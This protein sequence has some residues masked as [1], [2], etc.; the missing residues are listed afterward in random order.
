MWRRN[1]LKGQW[2]SRVAMPRGRAALSGLWMVVIEDD[3]NSI[4]P[5]VVV[6]GLERHREYPDAF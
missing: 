6:L 5:V 4:E 1:H 2:R 3:L